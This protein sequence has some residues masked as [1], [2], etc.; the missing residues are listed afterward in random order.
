LTKKVLG[1]AEKLHVVPA[2]TNGVSGFLMTGAPPFPL[3]CRALPRVATALSVTNTPLL[4]RFCCYCCCIRVHHRH[5]LPRPCRLEESRTCSLPCFSTW[6][7]SHWT[8][9]AWGRPWIERRCSPPIARARVV[10]CL[11]SIVFAIAT[12]AFAQQKQQQHHQPTARRVH[13]SRWDDVARVTLRIRMLFR[14][15]LK[16]PPLVTAGCLDLVACHREHGFL[17]ALTYTAPTLS[18]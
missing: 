13:S 18:H 14:V 16:R 7:V 9:D 5:Q 15:M 10:R 17:R 6:R 8:T 11:R 3:P 2:G 4:P 12:K 1:F